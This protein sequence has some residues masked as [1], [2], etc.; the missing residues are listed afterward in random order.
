M[1]VNIDHAAFHQEKLTKVGLGGLIEN[2]EKAF[3]ELQIAADHDLE[4][5]LDQLRGINS[6]GVRAFVIWSSNLQNKKITVHD[7]PK[8]FIDQL[9]LIAGFMPPQTQVRSFYVPYFSELTGEE[10]NILF[11]VGINFYLFEERWKLALPEVRDSQGHL[12]SIDVQAERYFKF[13]EKMRS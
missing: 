7:A 10:E 13:L 4:L 2:D 6:L 8:C 11:I 5:H 12:M 3:S 1:P 9:N